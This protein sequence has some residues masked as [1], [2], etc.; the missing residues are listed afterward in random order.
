MKDKT[1]NA[2]QPQETA[3]EGYRRFLSTPRK[4]PTGEMKKPL[5]TRTVD[6][7]LSK[8]TE[9]AAQQAKEKIEAALKDG[10]KVWVWSDQHFNHKNI[11]GFT[12][13]PF[14]SM[15]EMNK[16]MLRNYRAVVQDEDLVLFGGDVSFGSISEA[17][18]MLAGLP[19][20]KILVL[21]NHEVDKDGGWR[22]HACFDV[23]TLAFDFVMEDRLIWVTHV[24]LDNEYLPEGVV[25]LHGHTHRTLVG[26]RHINMSVELT[27]YA[28]VSLRELLQGN[29]EV[30]A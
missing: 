8:Q 6:A 21:G 19:G 23:V 15:D 7:L 30:V 3:M 27:G 13:R 25:N 22:E 18:A 26:P 12:D 4:I 10:R 2:A 11:I 20:E 24:P 9:G 28:P 17:R 16:A 14:E 5:R 1:K 29:N